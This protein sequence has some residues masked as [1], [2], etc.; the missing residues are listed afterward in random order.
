V[1]KNKKKVKGGGEAEDKEAE[2]ELKGEE[3]DKGGEG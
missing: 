2:E 3:E 1:I